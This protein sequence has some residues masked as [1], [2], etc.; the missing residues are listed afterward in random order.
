MLATGVFYVFT[1]YASAIGWGTGNMAAFAS[2]PNPYYDLGHALWGAGWWF[3]VLA[4][5]NSSIAV[6]LASTNAASR[7]MYTMGRAGTLP[8]RFGRIHPVYRTPTFAIAVQQVFGIVAMLIVGVLMSPEV[9]FGFL[10]T[11]SALAVIVLYVM[12][13][14]ALTAYM[15]REHP[16]Q[17]TVW[18]HV[19]VPWG[20]TLALIPV[21][22]VTVWPIPVWPYNL[23]PYVFIVLMLAGLPYMRWLELR[24]PGALQR[25]ATMLVGSRTSSEGEVDWSKAS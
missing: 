14:L 3:V 17:F 19:I 23:V 7:V 4:L 2:N 15:R 8:E 13:N 9:I 16:D 11:I 6:G 18:Q 22:I 1:S 24:H 20:A 5:F 25:G 10:E 12:A 21:L